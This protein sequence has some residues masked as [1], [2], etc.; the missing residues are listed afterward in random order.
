MGK[1][2]SM[3][4]LVTGATGF[5]GCRVVPRLLQQGAEVRCLVR[6]SSETA[7]LPQEADL[8]RGD[9]NDTA[10][11]EKAMSGVDALANIASLGFGHA[12]AVVRAAEKAGV[13]RAVF[14]STTAIFTN[15]NARSK[16]VRL[17]AEEVIRKST[18]R[19]TILRPT[20]IYGSSRDRNI[21][22][23]IRYIRRWP[24]I[25]VAGNGRSLQ[26]PVY[27]DDVARAVAQCLSRDNTI[28]EAYDL[29]G[30][31]ALSFDEMVD[32][33]SGLLGRRVRKVHLPVAPVA[34]LLHAC[35]RLS[36]RLPIRAE[37]ILRLNEDKT[38]D[39]SRAT[40]DFGFDP[41][42]FAEGIRMELHGLGLP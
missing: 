39:H 13:R 35:E 21:C 31:T 6:P 10:S 40:A 27:V 19:Y 30:A 25:P 26:Q 42:P 36:I 22:R 9:L 8:V 23:L 20:M 1:A 24:V 16:A 5:T 17:S 34:A 29:S 18:L 11:V 2:T 41:V 7:L 12:P 4:I 15:L 32:M 33:I 14:I 38:F 3:K 28:G 37:Q